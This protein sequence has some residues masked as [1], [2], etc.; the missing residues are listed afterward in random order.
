MNIDVCVVTSN[1]LGWDCV[2]GVWET[3]DEAKDELTEGY[4][5]PIS[6]TYVFTDT[7]VVIYCDPEE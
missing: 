7:S 5:Y 3:E 6:E 1:D 2:V 4:L